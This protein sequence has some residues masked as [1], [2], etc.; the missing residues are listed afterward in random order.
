MDKLI[1][2]VPITG[3]CLTIHSDEEGFRVILRYETMKV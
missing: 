3:D 1:F 2:T